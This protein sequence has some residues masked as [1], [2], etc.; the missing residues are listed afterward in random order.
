M[1]VIPQ[2]LCVLVV[3]QLKR[4]A[5]PMRLLRPLR[6]T[7]KVQTMAPTSFADM[8]SR[9]GDLRLELFIGS[10]KV[11]IEWPNSTT[12]FF[13]RNRENN[14]AN[15]EAAKRFLTFIGATYE[16]TTEKYWRNGDKPME[17][18]RITTA[19]YKRNLAEA[20]DTDMYN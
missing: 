5:T 17:V 16:S 20:Y 14:Q 8:L 19:S 15:L 9:Y 12:T 11:T 18:W 1:V 7:R 3:G 4:L 6:L 10:D 13:W 2:K